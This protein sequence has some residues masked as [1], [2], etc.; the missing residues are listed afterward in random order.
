M[1]SSP[2][3][4]DRWHGPAAGR[5][6]GEA[7]FGGGFQLQMAG[8][9]AGRLQTG[10]RACGVTAAALEQ[11]AKY[12]G[13]RRQ[14]GHPIGDYGLTRY[15]LGRMTA[16]LLAARAITYAAAPAVDGGQRSAAPV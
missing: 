15:H 2:L 5:V 9:A 16:R 14:F 12:V 13:E 4:L 1:H 6:G 10:G 11:T 7:G 3:A 8:F